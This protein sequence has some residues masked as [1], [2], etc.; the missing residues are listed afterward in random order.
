M[1][2]DNILQTLETL[3]NHSINA[4]NSLLA[5]Y[6]CEW[7]NVNQFSITGQLLTLQAVAI[8]TAD[9][10]DDKDTAVINHL[11]HHLCVTWSDKVKGG[12]L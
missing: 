10:A 6:L 11:T 3:K 7:F 12:S 1:K 8:V 5:T 2:Q 9:R 4:A